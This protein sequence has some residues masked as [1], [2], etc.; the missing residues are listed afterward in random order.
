M[1]E[2]EKR[3]WLLEKELKAFGKKID[4]LTKV[5]NSI[6]KDTE[7]LLSVQKTWKELVTDVVEDRSGK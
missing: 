1:D 7:V 3:L 2:I 5:V 4:L 6:K